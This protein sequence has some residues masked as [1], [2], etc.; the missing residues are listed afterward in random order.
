MVDILYT[1]A[2][3]LGFLPR[4][5]V[6]LMLLMEDSVDS[7]LIFIIFQIFQVASAPQYSV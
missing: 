5:I 4:I 1:S 7:S 2:D 6:K 3:V